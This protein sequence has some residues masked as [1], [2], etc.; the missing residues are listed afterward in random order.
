MSGFEPNRQRR[1]VPRWREARLSLPTGELTPL[2]SGIAKP[3]ALPEELGRRQEEWRQNHSVPFA[4]DLA[5]VALTL[6]VPE[7][8]HDA[9]EFLL[10]EGV[11]NTNPALA[12]LANAVL[13][14]L[15]PISI[16]P[17]RTKE[18]LSKAVHETRTRL[19]SEPRNGLLWVDLAR[20]YTV[21]GQPASAA[22]AMHRGLAIFPESRFVI[23]SAARFHIHTG[24]LDY[25]SELLRRNPRTPH[26]PWLLAAEVAVASILGRSPKHIKQAR[27]FVANE[28]LA[29]RHITELAAALGTL[30]L[31][32]GKRRDVRKL[33]RLSLEDPT[34]N[35]LAQVR[36]IA[37]VIPHLSIDP[38]LL[39]APRT[40]EARALEHFSRQEWTATMNAAVE[41]F[42]DE[43]F[44]SRP[45]RMAT[46]VGAVLLED[47]DASARLAHDALRASPKEQALRNNLVFAL[48]SAG[49]LEE[50]IEEAGLADESKMEAPLPWVWQA[51][52]GLLA[53][54]AGY[55]DVGR[56]LYRATIAATMEHYLETAAFAA[57]FLAREEFMAGTDGWQAALKEAQELAGKAQSPPLSALIARLSQAFDHAMLAE[58]PKVRIHVPGKPPTPLIL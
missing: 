37:N 58:P 45:A 27:S 23:R 14:R 29:R 44:S 16:L 47:Y 1:I 57:G 13:G 35:A 17:T 48:A 33:L 10:N 15:P 19:R 3:E 46:F 38:S 56:S 18:E 39:S 4:A 32:S 21:L 50:A 31:G 28:G 51:T 41:W 6:G 9:A 34:D 7:R 43:P 49:R 8:A 52:R 54:R 20:H 22:T 36:W 5:G 12:T 55:P 30:D 53:F 26:D 25:A 11:A 24:D 42:N 2:P 40:F